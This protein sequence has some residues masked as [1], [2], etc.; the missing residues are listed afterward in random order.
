MFLLNE[1]HGRTF[2]TSKL[3]Q[4]CLTIL[5]QLM[6]RNIFKYECY[7]SIRLDKWFYK[8]VPI[9]LAM[10]NTDNL[11]PYNFLFNNYAKYYANLSIKNKFLSI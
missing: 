6:P 3:I 10:F 1:L 7:I 2:A 8:K 9:K 11:N 4:L 5:Y